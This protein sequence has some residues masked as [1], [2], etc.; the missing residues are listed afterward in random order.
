MVSKEEA[1]VAF[2]RVSALHIARIGNAST[3]LFLQPLDYGAKIH[4]STLVY[5]GD[6]F[7]PHSVRKAAKY[8]L[9][10][11]Y[12]KIHTWFVFD[13][14]LYQISLHHVGDFNDVNVDELHEIASEFED[15][16]F[17]WREIFEEKDRQDLVHIP[18]QSK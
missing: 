17:K 14:E 10:T 4:L 18:A 7:I 3:G 2:D 5:R 9:E 12:S 15:A 1:K 11:P 13:E 8:Q 6:K 16:A